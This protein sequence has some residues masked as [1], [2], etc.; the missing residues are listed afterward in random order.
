LLV[1]KGYYFLFFGAIGCL[2]P[3]LNIFFQQ[4][5]LT[6]S[7]IGLLS[8]IPPL[9]ALTANPIWGAIADRWQIH[10]LVL[11]FC[12]L[13]AGTITLFFLQ[14]EEFVVFVLLVTILTFF[15]TPI[16]AIVD[17]A[18]M[19]MVKRG[20]AI[21][22]HQRLWGTIGF[23]LASFSLGQLLVSDDLSLVFWLHTA[24]LGV[25]CV[26]LGLMLPV[27][28]IDEA[29]GIKQGIQVLLTQRN[30]VSLLIAASLLGMGVAGYVGFM[31]LQ[32]V[33]LG[34]T[35]Q[36]V[37]LAWAINAILELPLMYFGVRWFAR[38]S[39]RRLILA[40]IFLFMAV[41]AL[42]GFSTTPTQVIFVVLGNGVCFGIYWVAAVGYANQAAPPGVSATAQALVGAGFS[43]LGWSLG[44]VIA[45]N[46]WDNS[47]GHTVFFFSAAMA[48]LA[49]LIFWLGSNEDRA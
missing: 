12:A 17:S 21:Y 27:Q 24:L 3:F 31:G 22:G 28:H 48:L 10:R 41:W 23:V 39:N 36:Q 15:R 1:A 19:D 16:G 46:L 30:Y 9:V 25:G 13:V 5:G 40:A 2:A 4:K 45:G 38:V 6:G 34:G 14:V 49:G 37:G 18:V 35:S 7:Q 44:S 33:A 8:S 20:N 32:V 26:V 47:G 29:V 43:G 42:L 11:A